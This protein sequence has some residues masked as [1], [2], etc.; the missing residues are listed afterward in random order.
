MGYLRVFHIKVL[1]LILMGLIGL[2][3]LAVAA[4]Y[5]YTRRQRR[6]PVKPESQLLAPDLLR[7][8]ETVEY[9][10][11]DKGILQ[12]RVRAAKLI[13]T[14][15]GKSLLQGISANSFNPDGSLR[16]EITSNNGEYD[17]GR[18]E[19]YFH[20]DVRLLLSRNVMIRMKSLRYNVGDQIGTSSDELQLTAPQIE[21]SAT[22]VRYDNARKD[23]ELQSALS[24]VVH[25]PVTDPDGNR[26]IED[27]QLKAERG[28]F[29][30][31]EFTAHLLGRASVVS[32]AG[33]LS[34][35][36]I[37]ATFTPDKRH[38]TS[39]SSHGN[40][41][42]ESQMEAGARSLRGDH[43]DFNIG[44]TSQ[45]LESIHAL[46]RAN[47]ALKGAD[48]AQDLTANEFNLVLDP[49]QGHPIRIEGQ[50]G[51]RFTLDRAAQRTE[52]SGEWLEAVFVPG[53]TALDSMN[54]RNRAGMKI[55]LGAATPDELQATEIRIA[56]KRVQ[57]RSMPGEF[58]AEG[59]VQWKTPGRSAK[60][61]ARTLTA[62]SLV[63]RYAAS[64]E[65]LESGTA[66]GN[67]NLTAAPK[68]GSTSAQ[69]QSLQCDRADFSFFGGNNRL[70]KLAADGHVR[71][72]QKTN[73]GPQKPAEEFSSS[74]AALTAQFRET[75]G[76][77]ES[78]TQSG[79]FVYQDPMRSAAADSCEFSAAADTMIL[80]GKP[81]VQEA[82]HESSG[83][84][85]EYDRKRD[86]LTIRRNVR[87]VLKSGS[88][89]MGFPAAPAREAS[90]V[91]VMAEELTYAKGQQK[92]VY[93]GRVRLLAADTQL[94]A[95]SLVIQD[96]GNALDA[97]GDVHHYL[98]RF[99][100]AE[101]RAS[102]PGPKI[103]AQAGDKQPRIRGPVDIRCSRLH[104][105]RS[106]NLIHYEGNVSMD[107]P[108]VK[109]RSDNMDA[110]FAADGG[111]LDRAL[112]SGNVLIKQGNRD[113]RGKEGEF[114]PNEG[115]LVVSGDAELKDP[116]KGRIAGR[117]L[118]FYTADDR[119]D[120]SSWDKR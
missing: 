45:V 117:R 92:A 63:M 9:D 53:E 56:F 97:E 17:S 113:I 81:R 93:S 112:A 8:A 34:G 23:I 36:R 89:S 44:S 73:P 105:L 114:F 71:V 42:Y 65:Y 22:G 95:Q 33:S 116:A 104:Y 115:K 90:P 37:D 77:L 55:H 18:K 68:P 41:V 96:R 84:V 27:Y 101:G 88:G 85:I 12:F 67:V 75:D 100:D 102:S 46:G 13:E 111:S 32:V 31:E 51:V 29:S 30:E 24:F 48:F 19:I 110:Y 66:G 76:G 49:V 14:R 54:I 16:N 20:G 108:D 28:M 69:L 2:V 60:D 120:V 106:R 61:I 52:V 6:D 21:G 26:Q 5:L 107:S 74:S 43:I 57:G 72:T 103:Q 10:S 11:W 78:I 99:G 94:Y 7:S 58:Q 82:D 35:D 50:R 118:T 15:E 1:R 38:L 25:R 59:A 70:Q 109:M 39:L 80:N 64:G 119:I 47:F 79:G 91:V 83:D 4:N 87:S 62:S 3:S 98:A 40:A 86:I